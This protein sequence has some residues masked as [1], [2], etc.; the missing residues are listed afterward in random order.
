L[1]FQRIL[2]LQNIADSEY[3]ALQMTMRRTR[4]PFTLGG[5]YTY[6]HSLDDSSDRSDPSFVNSADIKANHASSNFDQRH[7]LSINYI[8]DL[9]KMSGWFQA[10]SADPDEEGEAESALPVGDASFFRR[11]LDGWQV[12]G[13][14]IFQS[15]TPFSVINGGSNLGV[16]LLDNAGVANG[17]GAGSYPD[18]VGSPRS[19]LPVNISSKNS[20]SIGPLLYNPA[21]F[22]APQG[23]T[24]GNAG[25][26]F[27]NNPGRVNFDMSLLKTFTISEGRDVEFRVEA[28]NIFN[29]TQFRIF[30]PNLGNQANNTISCYAGGLSNYS[31]AGG[32]T[33]DNN[34]QPTPVD[35]TT[36]GSFLRPVDAHRPRTL[37]FGLKYSF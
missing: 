36:G 12:S 34:G 8:W 21:A 5:S 6:S 10:K 11:L 1:G 26:N 18:V 17:A 32:F 9:P 14:T 37:Q 2:S 16:S 3:H 29:H 19:P 23:L 31:A 15:G 4:G 35:C 33:A 22:A 27:L 13:I 25:R 28:F 30:N 7:L 20:Q 24:F